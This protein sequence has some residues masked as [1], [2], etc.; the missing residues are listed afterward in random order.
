METAYEILVA[1]RNPHIRNFLRREL[2]ALG[3]KV[4][5]V[6]NIQELLDHIYSPMPIHLLILDPDFPGIDSL[7]L[8]RKL[9][10]R[11]PPLPVVLHCVQGAAESV[12]LKESEVIRIK[13]NGNSVEVIKK[14][15]YDLFEHRD[16]S[17]DQPIDN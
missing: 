13:K 1:D 17:L 8:G 10:T 14:V 11:I 2:T 4:R 9:E 3:L 7:N 12:D 6:K 5:L 16:S 15:I